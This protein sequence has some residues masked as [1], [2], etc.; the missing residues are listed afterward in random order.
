[1]AIEYSKKCFINY[2]FF[3]LESPV[4]RYYDIFISLFVFV[5][6]SD[7]SD[8]GKNDANED[9]DGLALVWEFWGSI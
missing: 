8:S 5:A 7:S 9:A 2:L 4:F 3:H 1:M 6:C